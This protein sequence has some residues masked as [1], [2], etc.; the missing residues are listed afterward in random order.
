[1]QRQWIEDNQLGRRNLTPGQFKLLL[2]RKYNRAK[3]AH[4]GDRRSSHQ[5]DDLKTSERI[6]NEHGVSKA[7]VERSGRAADAIDK[8]VPEVQ[9]GV[10][11]SSARLSAVL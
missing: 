8:A 4:G 2:G 11:S 7:T 6:A 1:M 10:Q 5:T 3:K 9:R